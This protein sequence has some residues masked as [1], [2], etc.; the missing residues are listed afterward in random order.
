MVKHEQEVATS[1]FVIQ[2]FNGKIEGKSKVNLQ[3]LVDS[4]Q[5]NLKKAIVEP[6]LKEIGLKVVVDG[7]ET[8]IVV[9]NEK[10]LKEYYQWKIDKANNQKK[11][12]H[13]NYAT[14]EKL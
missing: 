9:E 3:K 10:L 5:S 8:T 7:D 12:L 14:A 2:L 11:I 4:L 6:V 1:T 13:K